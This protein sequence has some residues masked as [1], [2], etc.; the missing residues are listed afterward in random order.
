MKK[1]AFTTLIAFVLVSS[2]F[3]KEISYDEQFG[4]VDLQAGEDKAREQMEEDWVKKAE[5]FYEALQ[6]HQESLDEEARSLMLSTKNI[7]IGNF[8]NLLKIR[9]VTTPMTPDPNG[10]EISTGVITSFNANYNEYFIW[11]PGGEMPFT[12]D[13]LIKIMQ[14]LIIGIYAF[15][16]D[17][18]LSLDNI[19]GSYLQILLMPPYQDSIIGK[20]FINLDYRMKSYL[21][22]GYFPMEV[23]DNW[24]ADWEKAKNLSE[25]NRV[26]R[27]YGYIDFHNNPAYKSSLDYF[28][29]SY[30]NDETIRNLLHVGFQ[31]DGKMKE[32]ISYQ[33]LYLFEVSP[34]IRYHTMWLTSEDDFKRRYGLQYYEVKRC[35]DSLLLDVTKYMKNDPEMIIEMQKLKIIVE[36]ANFF[37]TLK[38]NGLIPLIAERST[39]E[40]RS[41]GEYL[42]KHLTQRVQSVNPKS[43]QFVIEGGIGLSASREIP[44]SLPKYMQD[45]YNKN[46]DQMREVPFNAVQKI[47]NVPSGV[48]ILHIAVT[49]TNPGDDFSWL[50]SLFYPTS[51]IGRLKLLLDSRPATPDIG[52]RS[53]IEFF[54][55]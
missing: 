12:N 42:P 52:K 29:D 2:V 11:L 27:R 18:M 35:L 43:Y 48:N 31:V 49:K 51:D 7:A 20:T 47:P 19:M 10:V 44:N 14:E 34:E 16:T 50:L 39:F 3:T 5:R 32:A 37:R 23:G 55:P 54:G 46:I 53:G 21:N 9:G 4:E 41:Y 22:G 28:I 40:C 30:V 45:I 17:P 13:E 25:Q 6:R 33:N 15:N 24:L 36:L 38:T 8:G 26:L 1:I